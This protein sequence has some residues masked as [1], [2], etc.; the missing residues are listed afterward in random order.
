[1]LRPYIV[2][3]F[4]LIRPHQ[5]GTNV[6]FTFCV[7]FYFFYIKLE[8]FIFSIKKSYYTDTRFNNITKAYFNHEIITGNYVFRGSHKIL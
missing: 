7:Y 2:S 1:M 8:H 6:V 4:F 5:C 3:S